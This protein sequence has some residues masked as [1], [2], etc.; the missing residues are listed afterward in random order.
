MTV[1]MDTAQIAARLTKARADRLAIEPFS[2]EIDGFDLPAAYAVQRQ[3]RAEAGPL[4]GWKLGVTS[5]AKQAQVGV[6]EPVRGFL[7]AQHALDLG[8]PLLVGNHIQPRAEPE[9]V[10]MMGADLSGPAVT[11]ADVLAATHR[12]RSASRYSTPGTGTTSSRWLM[13]WPT[14]PR[15]A[16]SSSARRCR[17]PGWTCA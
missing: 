15:P 16:G 9:I 11:S 6:R 5:R 12:L 13:W 7:A 3:L 1:P 4:A 8:E 10:F 14:T 17:R 2:A